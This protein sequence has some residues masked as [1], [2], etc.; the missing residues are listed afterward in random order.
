MPQAPGI[1]APE[2]VDRLRPAWAPL[3]SEV[4]ANLA[5]RWI[6]HSVR[7][8]LPSLF[9]RHSRL[10]DAELVR[11]LPEIVD[12]GTLVRAEA[13]LIQVARFD[14]PMEMLAALFCALG[15]FGDLKVKV[16]IADSCFLTIMTSRMVF[17]D[18]R[19][20]ETMTK[21]LLKTS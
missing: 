8:A 21:D 9:E 6:D 16:E 17:G 7:N 15:F 18:D 20:M 13:A 12:T 11:S 1:S 4:K 3:T 19:L 10:V 2:Q 14:Q 5:Y